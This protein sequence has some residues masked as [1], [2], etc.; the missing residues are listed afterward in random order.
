MS[1]EC[2]VDGDWKLLSVQHKSSQ[3]TFS[4][5]WSVQANRALSS[6]GICARGI[7]LYASEQN[8]NKYTIVS[9]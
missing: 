2:Q 4:P 6:V 5:P 1:E 9:K 3:T 7:P 8:G